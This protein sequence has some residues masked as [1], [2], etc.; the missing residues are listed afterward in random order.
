MAKAGRFDAENPVAYGSRKHRA[1][2]I[3]PDAINSYQLT[4]T[5]LDWNGLKNTKPHPTKLS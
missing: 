4:F 5:V 2:S 1:F 3:L